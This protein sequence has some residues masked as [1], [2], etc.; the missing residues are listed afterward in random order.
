MQE[1]VYQDQREIREMTEKNDSAPGPD[2]GAGR[3][4]M[5]EDIAIRMAEL[6]HLREQVKKANSRCLEPK[7][8]DP[9][10]ASPSDSL[11]S[12]DQ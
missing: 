4:A 11:Q 6:R 10:N 1:V 2:L 3:A 8:S 9:A 12:P 5:V 7:I